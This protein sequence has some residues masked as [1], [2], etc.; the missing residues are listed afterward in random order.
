[1]ALTTKISLMIEAVDGTN[2]DFAYSNNST[3]TTFN[4]NIAYRFKIDDGVIDYQLFPASP[5]LIDKCDLFFIVPDQDG[6]AL[7]FSAPG[8]ALTAGIGVRLKAGKPT[9][10]QSNN[11]IIGVWVSND[12]GLPI[13]GRFFAA[14]QE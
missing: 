13:T 3:E 14:S 8:H 6:L 4:E 5:T 2:Y 10:Y 9:L 12:T 1:M 7:K 11:D